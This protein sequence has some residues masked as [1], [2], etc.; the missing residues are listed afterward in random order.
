V[1]EGGMSEGRLIDLHEGCWMR[2]AD[3]SRI[4]AFGGA[5]EVEGWFG[6]IKHAAKKARVAVVLKDGSYL[7]WWAS[8]FEDAVRLAQDMAAAVNGA[9]ESAA[10][11]P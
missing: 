9:P 10:D 1:G 8:S 2:A 4:V 7:E 11:A 3:I 6:R 5:P